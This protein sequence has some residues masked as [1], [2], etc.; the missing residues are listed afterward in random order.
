MLHDDGAIRGDAETP[1]R[2]DRAQFA[3]RIAEGLKRLP[4][5]TA[6]VISVE[7]AWGTGKTS[8]LNLVK[9][10]FWTWPESQ[11]PIVVNFNPWLVGRAEQLVQAFIVQ[12]AAAI[13][14]QD[15]AGVGAIAAKQLL[16]YSRIFDL[17]RLVPGAEPW[18]TMVKS[19]V[20]AVGG[21]A[22]K[23]SNLKELD[24][25]KRRKA[26]IDALAD[27]D[28][29]I[30][31]FIDDLDRLPPQEVTEMV[32]L[33]KAVGEFPGLVYLLAFDGGY[34]EKALDQ[35]GI[36]ESRSY[37]DKIV[38]V[39]LH[40]PD[41]DSER[42]MVLIDEEYNALPEAAKTALPHTDERVQDVFYHGLRDLL[43][44]PR[45]VKRLFNRLYF[46]EPAC[47]GE[48]SLGDLMALEAIALK[49]P[50]VYRHI[51]ED[52]EAYVGRPLYQTIVVIEREKIVEQTAEDRK[53]QI[54]IL[55]HGL[56]RPI[57]RLL[58]KLFPLTGSN[59]DWDRQPNASALGLIQE[60][61]RLAIALSAGLPLREASLS[62]AYALIVKP[63]M[64]EAILNEALARGRFTRLMGHLT[65]LVE[66]D[67]NDLPGLAVALG[68]ALDTSKSKDAEGSPQDDIFL[69]PSRMIWG[70]LEE[71]LDRIEIREA[72]PVVLALVKHHTCVSL[73]TRTLAELRKRIDMTGAKTPPVWIPSNEWEVLIE[74][75]RENVQ[76]WVLAGRVN[77]LALGS[78]VLHCLWKW[79]PGKAKLLIEGFL[80]SDSGTDQ[81]MLSFSDTGNDSV[82]GRF[83]Q[84]SPDDLELFGGI[85]RLGLVAKRRLAETTLPH[86]LK[87][88]Y[89]A[90]LSGK[91]VYSVDASEAV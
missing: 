4:P 29:R 47:R 72:Y 86:R 82:K 23:V 35:Q 8:V 71:Q 10:T 89:K 90:I 22:E 45:D 2:L 6:I 62:D 19:V 65:S 74:L 37:L 54:A 25:D 78:M 41:A 39:R 77:D 52:P 83:V 5:S 33:I 80:S 76:T 17:L 36:P 20:E 51:R 53:N 55:S 27:L 28:R 87:V 44:T 59:A 73:A 38:Q 26:V 79:C 84:L 63:N 68:Q 85:E 56:K 31:I 3:E 57:Q 21:A 18:A 24:L 13:E 32:R 67:V 69:N 60:P 9:R 75:W 66:E 50:E 91:R 40:V 46:V 14:L 42:M 88:I 12:L 16:A 7:G 64:R 34:L 15:H 1:D 81:L 11:R 61:D 70:F 48:I 30:V 58:H 49:A 43:E